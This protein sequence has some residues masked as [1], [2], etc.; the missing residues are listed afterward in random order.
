MDNVAA[1]EKCWS[2]KEASTELWQEVLRNRF[3]R[4]ASGQQL[5]TP[6]GIARR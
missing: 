1:P 5:T 2:S 6:K 4:R 3:E